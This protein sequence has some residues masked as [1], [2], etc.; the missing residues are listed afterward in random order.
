M[1]KRTCLAVTLISLLTAGSVQAQEFYSPD[2]TGSSN[3]TTVSFGTANQRE[4]SSD[5]SVVEAVEA[6]EDVVD[7]E[8]ADDDDAAASQ[9]A[10]I[11]ELREQVKLMLSLIHI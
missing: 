10:T 2:R 9:A 11:E 7:L 8:V 1:F 4:D 3:F 6:V 5:K